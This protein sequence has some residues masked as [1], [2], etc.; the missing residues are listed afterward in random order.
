MATAATPP[1]REPNGSILQLRAISW[2]R[3]RNPARLAQLPS[4]QKSPPTLVIWIT[5]RL[6]ANRAL[7][8]FGRPYRLPVRSLGIRAWQPRQNSAKRLEFAGSIRRFSGTMQTSRAHPW[9]DQR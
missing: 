7:S 8:L 2:P 6:D 1:R 4:N 5:I 3:F 9:E